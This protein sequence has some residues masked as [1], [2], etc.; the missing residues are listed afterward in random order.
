M[1]IYLHVYQYSR[2]H[3]DKYTCIRNSASG[4]IYF[5]KM[6]LQKKKNVVWL[7][8]LKK[9]CRKKCTT[10]TFTYSSVHTIHIRPNM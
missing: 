4:K 9:N 6:I 7:K 1:Y 8:Q 2:I 5:L 10:N 3:V